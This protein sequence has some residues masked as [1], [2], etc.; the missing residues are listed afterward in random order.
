MDP[1]IE[2]YMRCRKIPLTRRKGEHKTG[3]KR[4]RVYDWD[5]TDYYQLPIYSADCALLGTES[6]NPCYICGKKEN[7]IRISDC[8][9][10]P[11]HRI[12]LADYIEKN[13]DMKCP[14]CN[15]RMADRF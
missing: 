11:F 4:R 10:T 14:K 2:E 7:K 9:Y 8:C 6:E 3:R 5:A 12:C 15:K 13:I 1:A